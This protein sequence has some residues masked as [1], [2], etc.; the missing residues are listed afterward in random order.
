[1]E[2]KD[3]LNDISII[4]VIGN[5]Q[6]GLKL[7]GKVK[8]LEINNLNNAFKMVGLEDI[9]LDKDI[10]NLS[11]SE[12]WKV[13]LATK[14]VSDI[15]I[16]GNLSNSL[17]HKDREYMKKLFIKLASDYNKKIVIIDNNVNVFFNL[18]KK[19][20]VLK[21]K[22][23]IY[24]TSNF[25]DDKLYEYVK[26]PKIINFVKFVNKNNKRLDETIDIYELIK[27]IYR[28]VS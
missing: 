11:L 21:D 5:Y 10:N 4:G 9:V 6:S 25:Y 12:L 23:I 22:K 24:E 2:I 20:C 16:I 19:I 13:E 17:N 7:T 27:D 14:L 1:M 8:D 3:I 15:I 28:R 18:A 26:I